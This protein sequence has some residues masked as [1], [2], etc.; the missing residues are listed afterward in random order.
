VTRRWLRPL[1]AAAA[2]A[3]L[4]LLAQPLWAP[5]PDGG[6]VAHAAGN[7]NSNA[8]GNGNGN[9]GGNNA[10]GNSG[11]SNAGGNGNGN[12]GGSN[13]GG[14]GNGNSGG[15]NAGG[16]GNGNSGGSNAG[17]N[18][19]GNSGGSNAGGN[20]NGNSGGSN[21][22]GNGN[23]N[24][25]GSNAGGNGNGNSG[26]SNA[27]GNGNGNSGGSGD[28]AG[29][30]GASAAT[31]T[32]TQVETAASPAPAV[33]TGGTAQAAGSL[34]TV[35]SITPDG[36]HWSRG[37][38]RVAAGQLLLI[39]Q[40]V[41]VAAVAQSL[42]FAILEER[43]L[44]AL[45]LDVVRVGLPAGMAPAVGRS[46]LLQR[47]PGI[48]VDYDDLYSPEG[49]FSLPP[50]DYPRR[51]VAW[52]VAGPRCG[53]G[54]RLGII[55]SAVSATLPALRD[56]DL[57]RRSF[58]VA[59]GGESG[60][61]TAI[62]AILVGASGIGLLPGATLRAAQI[63]GRDAAGGTTA[64]AVAFAAAL[65]WLV[66]E[67]TQVVNLSLAGHDNRLVAAAVQRAA[68]RGAILVAAAGND[69][70]TAP[71]AYP[72][73]YPEV[74]AVAAVDA[75]SNPDPA[76]NRGAYIAFAAP[77]VQVWT[78][79]PEGGQFNTGSSFAAPFVTGA[80]G[81][82]LLDGSPADRGRVEA[83]LAAEAVDLGAPGRD[84]VFG[85]GLI[86]ARPSCAIATAS[87]AP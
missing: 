5:G 43:R 20:G 47:R 85:W 4:G 15:S 19:N 72:A 22:G 87:A 27:G 82:A 1:L 81:A 24:S 73:A 71:P 63:F 17:G 8:G 69:G 48:T 10:G 64:D 38:R 55:D 25:G 21:A 62:A 11:G 44:P 78:P 80:V 46:L 42:G 60:H 39:D 12:S 77:G 41:A 6:Q 18:G 28:D 61:G 7:G 76:G 16:N 37:Q 57:H 3:L 84:P 50:S 23:G 31:G 49:T 54:L 53:V 83:R 45:E 13:A 30:T 33:S 66:G 74:I 59:P 65:D 67:R 32:A 70:P 86:R 29:G 35:A 52:G 2:L 58:G 36:R 68:A 56:A 14:N 9:S 26:G 51:L 79:S 75:R 34:A 40:P